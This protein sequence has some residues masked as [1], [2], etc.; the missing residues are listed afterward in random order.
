MNT[1]RLVR[2]QIST[3]IALVVCALLAGYLF[4][5]IPTGQPIWSSSALANS[6]IKTADLPRLQ[7]DLRDAVSSLATFR[8]DK[9]E[10]LLVCLAAIVGCVCFFG[11]SLFLI[12]RIKKEA[13]RA[14]A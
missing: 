13:S 1:N 4:F 12:S 7:N 5:T 14:A 8:R 6:E 2:L 10:L 11:W 9:N 3:A